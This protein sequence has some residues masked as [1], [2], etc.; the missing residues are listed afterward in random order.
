MEQYLD[1]ISNS[2]P[3]EETVIP[4]KH[5]IFWSFFHINMLLKKSSNHINYQKLIIEYIK[6]HIGQ[7]IVLFYRV[8]AVQGSCF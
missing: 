4:S 3:G 1:Q 5:L 8:T 7:N 2:L 6:V